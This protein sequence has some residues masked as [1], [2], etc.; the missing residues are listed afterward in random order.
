MRKR[1]RVAYRLLCDDID[2]TGNGRGSEKSRTTAAHHLYPID[3]ICRNL[4]NAIDACKGA[5][6]RTRIYKYLSIRTVKTVYTHLLVAAVLA[7]V[8]HPHSGLEHESLRKRCGIYSLVSL[9]IH[10]I[11]E[12]RSHHSCRLAAVCRHDHSVE[13][14]IVFLHI[15]VHFQSHAVLECNLLIYSLISYAGHL[16]YEISLRKMLQKIVSAVSG[17]STN[18]S[19]LQGYH[20]KWHMLTCILIKH[21]TM[22]TRLSPSSVIGTPH[23][24][25]NKECHQ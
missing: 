20:K 2:G 17:R 12:G 11:D 16:K 9:H 18:R 5:E 15:K 8:L 3:H 7:V 4:L 22:N 23:R 25:R 6:N 21:M 10:D 14:H 13:H 24:N 19:S 1:S